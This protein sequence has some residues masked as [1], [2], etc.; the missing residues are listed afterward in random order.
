MLYVRESQQRFAQP[1]A[2]RG[3]ARADLRGHD[4]DRVEARQFV[5]IDHIGLM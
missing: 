2:V 4:A 1:C 5:Q 3:K